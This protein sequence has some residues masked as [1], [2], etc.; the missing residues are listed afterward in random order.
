MVSGSA[1]IN[2]I[3]HA[4]AVGWFMLDFLV[5]HG[6]AGPQ[7]TKREGKNLRQRCHWSYG[8][9]HF[10]RAVSNSVYVIMCIVRRWI[11]AAGARLWTGS[12]GGWEGRRNGQDSEHCLT[13]WET[14]VTHSPTGLILSRT[15][16]ATGA[17]NLAKS[18]KRRVRTIFNSD[19]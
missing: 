10:S 7:W 17:N 18:K 4:G 13:Y 6:S 2:P 16:G 11:S 15:G 14:P 9:C 1:K 19:C 12:G 8:N 3:S 5:F